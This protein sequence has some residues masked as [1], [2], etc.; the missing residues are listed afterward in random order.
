MGHNIK[1]WQEIIGKWDK[2]DL[3]NLLEQWMA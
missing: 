2:T 3:R 1:E